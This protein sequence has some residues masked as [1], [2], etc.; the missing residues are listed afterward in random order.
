MQKKEVTG[1]TNEERE[2]DLLRKMADAEAEEAKNAKLF[3]PRDLLLDAKA[4]HQKYSKKLGRIVNYGILSFDEVI[5]VTKIEDKNEASK[6]MLW[7][8]LSKAFP[9]LRKEDVG[10]F[11]GA[12]FAE[13]LTLL[14]K[15]EDFLP[16]TQKPAPKPS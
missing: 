1:K 13:L 3:D 5:G 7:M 14:T 6:T 15:D 2:Q 11:S 12:K 16:A 4:I 10:K 9:D 8:M